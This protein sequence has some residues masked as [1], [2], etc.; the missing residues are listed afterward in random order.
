MCHFNELNGL[1]KFVVTENCVPK[2]QENMVGDNEEKKNGKEAAPS[3]ALL[4]K[5]YPNSAS[6]EKSM[7]PE[8][9]K[10]PHLE[11]H[12]AENK[13]TGGR[14]EKTHLAKRV[15]TRRR[16]TRSGGMQER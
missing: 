4:I 16:G 12:F 6:H 15:V 7:P 9:E 5:G 11:A 10:S 14:H 3:G 1:D 13:K 8:L 2:E